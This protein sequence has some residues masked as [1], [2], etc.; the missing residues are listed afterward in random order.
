[1]LTLSDEI[2]LEDLKGMIAEARTK[3]EIKEDFFSTLQAEIAMG[4]FIKTQ[5]IVVLEGILDS[6]FFSKLR[7]KN[8]NIITVED[9][10]S[11]DFNKQKRNKKLKMRQKKEI[12]SKERKRLDSAK[13]LVKKICEYLEEKG[14]DFVFGI[15]DTDLEAINKLIRYGKYKS[16]KSDN[17]FQTFPCRD[18]ELLIYYQLY[19]NDVFKDR[20]RESLVKSIDLSKNLAYVGIGLNEFNREYRKQAFG[21]NKFCK[22]SRKSHKEYIRMCT[23]TKSIIDAFVAYTA[24]F[25][26][27][28]KPKLLDFVDNVNSKLEEN[29][30]GWHQ[31]VRG[32]DLETIITITDDKFKDVKE[33]NRFLIMLLKFEYVENHSLIKQIIEW[34]KRLDLPRLFEE[35]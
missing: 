25:P 13:N 26:E 2:E 17:I 28:D 32:H 14:F 19:E 24:S 1:M 8:L 20:L 5:P 30:L 29:E 31:I 10:I 33:V 27:E 3:T 21:L 22:E 16:R 35:E 4:Q 11:K 6:Q 18:M 34:R 12:E 9:L 7:S 15:Q 23:S